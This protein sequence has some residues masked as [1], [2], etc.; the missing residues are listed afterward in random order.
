M[1][2]ISA[3]LQLTPDESVLLVVR[4]HW[5]VIARY[6]ATVVLLFL[7]PF[8]AAALLPLLI[9][10]IP[11]FF[12]PEDVV[13]LFSFLLMLYL[14]GVLLFLMLA[15]TDYYLDTWIITSKRII[16]IEQKGLFR[17]QISEIPLS[18][19]QDVT[20]TVEGFFETLLKFGAVHIQTAG[21][22]NFSIQQVPHL[23]R[24]KDTVLSALHPEENHG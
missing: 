12:N 19:V 23:E 1:T 2:A 18:R 21:E 20:L 10:I 7:L 3:I 6:F 17:R 5:L 14:M 22:R 16:D 4:K 9:S 8:F 24:I 11:P 13:P 15:W